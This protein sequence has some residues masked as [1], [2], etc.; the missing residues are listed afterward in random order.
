[1]HLLKCHIEPVFFLPASHIM[2]SIEVQ[3]HAKK[4]DV[5]Y[6]TLDS[7]VE[8]LVQLRSD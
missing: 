4:D 8:F 1:L 5:Y 2:S 6:C 7:V 3:R